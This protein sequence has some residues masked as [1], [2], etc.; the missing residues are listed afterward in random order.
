M[1]GSWND[2]GVTVAEVRARA[3]TPGVLHA[4]AWRRFPGKGAQEG[5]ETLLDVARVIARFAGQQFAAAIA[6]VALESGDGHRLAQEWQRG[7]QGGQFGF[8]LLAAGR[9]HGKAM[10]A[11]IR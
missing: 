8:E 4:G 5:R 6:D 3:C 1:L 9:L 7:L 2:G 11:R 10:V